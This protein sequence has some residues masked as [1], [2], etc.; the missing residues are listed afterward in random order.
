MT[1]KYQLLYI[2]LPQFFLTKF[3]CKT[4]FTLI[5]LQTLIFYYRNYSHSN[6]HSQYLSLWTELP[7]TLCVE[8]VLGL[9]GWSVCIC[10]TSRKNQTWSNPKWNFIIIFLFWVPTNWTKLTKHKASISSHFMRPFFVRKC[11][12]RQNLTREKHFHTI[13]A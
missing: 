13:R 1:Q 9:W 4:N 7:E 10:K 12:F 8:G 11:F 3:I 2:Q 5:L 6:V